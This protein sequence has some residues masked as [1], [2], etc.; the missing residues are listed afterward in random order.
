MQRSGLVVEYVVGLDGRVDIN[1]ASSE[2]IHEC[3]FVTAPAAGCRSA[4]ETLHGIRSTK[5]PRDQGK[6][7][8]ASLR[9]CY[10]LLPPALYHI[11]W[12]ALPVK[13]VNTVAISPCLLNDPETYSNLCMTVSVHTVLSCWFA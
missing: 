9:L 12:P 8:L 6:F 1:Y 10:P 2:G 7:L 13:E 3:G 11:D 4:P 5:D